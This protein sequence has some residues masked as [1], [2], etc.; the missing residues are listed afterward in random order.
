MKLFEAVG[1]L[2]LL[3]EQ[4]PAMKEGLGLKSQ[5]AHSEISQTL[6][7][8]L[9]VVNLDI[10]SENTSVPPTFA[11]RELVSNGDDAWLEEL[12]NG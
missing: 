2:F 12:G 9:S 8:P 5:S 3:A 11:G 10:C 6:A 4:T 1:H 7:E